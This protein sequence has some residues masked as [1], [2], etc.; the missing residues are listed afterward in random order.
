MTLHVHYKT[1]IFLSRS[2]QNIIVKSLRSLY[3]R[4]R[5][6]RRQIF[7]VSI[8]KLRLPSHNFDA[9]R[10]TEYIQPFTKFVREIQVH[11]SIDVLL[12]VAVVAA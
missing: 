5:D 6:F 4:Q 7:H 12:G 2:L 1:F 3:L 9:V 8:G 11:F 10:Q